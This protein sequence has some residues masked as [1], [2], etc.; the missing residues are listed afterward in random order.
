MKRITKMAALILLALNL[1]ACAF[2]KYVLQEAYDDKAQTEC[3]GTPRTG[4]ENPIC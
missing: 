3:E 1:S 4:T 2:T